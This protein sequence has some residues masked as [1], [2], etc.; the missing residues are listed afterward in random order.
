MTR[1]VLLISADASW[2][3]A[4]EV[5]L[6]DAREVGEFSTSRN[7]LE[8]KLGPDRYSLAV[9]HADRP[10][11]GV[12][13]GGRVVACR[14]IAK[15]LREGT[16]F[17]AGDAALPIVCLSSLPDEQLNSALGDVPVSEQMI[18]HDSDAMATVRELLIARERLASRALPRATSGQI[19][20]TVRQAM[21]EMVAQVGATVKPFPAGE[22]Y[23]RPDLEDIDV[24]FRVREHGVGIKEVDIMLARN[25]LHRHLLGSR[26]GEALKFCR[27]NTI[28]NTSVQVRFVVE[29]DDLEHVPFE[30][31]GTAN[32][33]EY[34]RDVYPTAR[35]LHVGLLHRDPDRCLRPLVPPSPSIL[36]IIADTQGRLEK[37]GHTFK[38]ADHIDLAPLGYLTDERRRLVKLHGTR[39]KVVRLRPGSA[40]ETLEAALEAGPYDVIHFIGHSAKSDVVNEVFLA[41]PGDSAGQ[42]EAYSAD[43]FAR[44]AADADARLVILSSCEN[45][46][47]RSML[48]LASFGIPAVIGFRWPVNDFDAS[49][50]TPLLHRKL[51]VER[52]PVARAFHKTLVE[53]KGRD[54]LTRFSPILMLQTRLW[55]EFAMECGVS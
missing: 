26:L 49:R 48:R 19:E 13:P 54:Y 6:E 32:R 44:G 10:S 15:A 23:G 29:P 22:W 50:F 38:G 20:I 42:V 8:Q 2:L 25:R 45:C 18:A 27:D 31:A 51:Y 55:H 24:E 41:L 4:L 30:L 37:E 33:D 3:D 52:L 7:Q 21:I 40:A 1:P 47:S 17:C 16:A 53:F 14:E 28:D 11:R 36:L 43:W 35:K 34:L 12:A 39:I 46:S 9:I 5:S